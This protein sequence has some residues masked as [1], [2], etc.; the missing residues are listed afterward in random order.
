MNPS[1]KTH[2]VFH[3]EVVEKIR[4]QGHI[5]IGSKIHLESVPGDG[6]KPIRY[7]GLLGIQAR[8]L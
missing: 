7:S 3:V 6:P 4:D 5:V 8:H 2:A 1:E